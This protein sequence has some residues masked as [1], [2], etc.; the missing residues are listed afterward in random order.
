MKNTREITPSPPS[1]FLVQRLFAIGGWLL[2]GGVIGRDCFLTIAGKATVIYCM[3]HKASVM[4]DGWNLVT[5][6]GP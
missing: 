2:G 3:F 6:S 4:N 1:P 5:S